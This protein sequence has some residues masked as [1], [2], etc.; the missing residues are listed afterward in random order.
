MGIN[1]PLTLIVTQAAVIAIIKTR[2]NILATKFKTMTIQ[3]ANR[4]VVTQFVATK[5]LY[6]TTGAMLIVV[7]RILNAPPDAAT[8]MAQY[9]NPVT[10][11]SV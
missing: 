6:M 8:F 9:A 4:I 7:Q 5:V 3:C 10:I 11:N 1:A 2:N